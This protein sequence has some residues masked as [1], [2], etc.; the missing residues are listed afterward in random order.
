MIQENPC[1]RGIQLIV[2]I[3]EKKNLSRTTCICP[4]SYYGDHCQYQN[5][6]VSL[7][8]QCQTLSDSWSTLFTIVI[9]LI[10][11]SE[12]RIIHSYEQ[13]TYLSV[14][15]CKIKF[16]IY[17]LYSNRPKSQSQ[18]YSIHIDVYEKVSLDYRASFLYPIKFFFLPVH[19]Q[20]LIIIIPGLKETIK[21]CSNLKCIHG[22]CMIYS[23]SQDN[24]TFCQCDP[25]WSGQYCTIKYDCKCSSDSK[26]IGLSAHNRS[27]CICPINK[28]GYQ[29]L[30]TDPVCQRND[31]STCLNGGRCIPVDEYV[32]SQRKFYCICPKGYIGE[33]CEIPEKKIIISF[34]K[35]LVVSQLIFIHF[36]EVIKDI[37][38]KRSTTLKMMIVRQNSLTIYWS[39]IFHM[40]FIEFENKI[41]YLA[42]I[43]QI[44]NLS[45]TL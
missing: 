8:I 28:F 35:N 5:Q 31:N 9:S 15:D 20:A 17:L 30:L 6:R 43:E 18:N 2:W 10:D 19:R 25:G 14:R 45:M 39:Q 38:P 11:H 32:S 42:A 27:I 4:P 24:T 22:K 3:D 44:Y 13:L 7:T 23:Y 16:N 29:C 34:D 12:Q 40:I 41:Y 26:C 37:T 21:S 1:N 33:R 36:L